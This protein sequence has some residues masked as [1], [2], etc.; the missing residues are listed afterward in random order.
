MLAFNFSKPKVSSSNK[1]WLLCFLIYMG[2]IRTIIINTKVTLLVKTLSKM[3]F[4]LHAKIGLQIMQCKVAKGIRSLGTWR[5]SIQ[6]ISSALIFYRICKIKQLKPSHFVLKTRQQ[7]A[8]L[9]NNNTV[10]FNIDVSP[11]KIKERKKI[12]QSAICCLIET[13]LLKRF[14]LESPALFCNMSTAIGT[15]SRAQIPKHHC[16]TFFLNSEK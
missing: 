14:E 4:L 1:K 8:A 5:E 9:V 12:A 6:K 10:F 15:I 16:R 7:K 2:Y 11:S 3:S 13:L